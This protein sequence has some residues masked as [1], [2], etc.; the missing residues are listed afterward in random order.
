MNIF[1]KILVS[2]GLAEVREDEEEKELETK[3]EKKKLNSSKGSK[4]KGSVVPLNSKSTSADYN[5]LIVAPGDYEEAKRISEFIK[6]SK[7]VIVNLENLDVEIGRQLVDFVSGTVFGLDG[8]VHKIGKQIILFSPPNVD[9]VDTIGT[10]LTG[11]DWGN[12]E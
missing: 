10:E 4:S 8:T 3:E 9:I 5:I 12:F 6:D 1:E 2:L 7:P 11:E